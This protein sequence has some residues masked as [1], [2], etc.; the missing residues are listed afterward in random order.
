MNEN[1]NGGKSATSSNRKKRGADSYREGYSFEDKVA[2]LYRLLHYNVEHGRIFGGRQVDLFITTSFGDMKL[3]RAIECKAGAVLVEHIDSFIAKLRLVR[4]EYPAALGTI[5]SG[6][7]FTDAVT[8]HAVREGIQL[9]LHRDL[10]AQLFDGYGYAQNLL[11]ECESS[12]RYRIPLYIEPSIGYDTIGQGINAFEVID[13]W[14]ND[15]E[16]NQLTLL[17]DA[18]TGKSFLSRMIAYRLVQE[19][20]KAPLATLFFSPFTPS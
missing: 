19:Y 10:A 16:W 3:Q 6:V 7:S 20:L 18:G 11:R 5:V 14:L 15:P 13:Q 12:T 2:E 9:T 4:C 8:A 1:S 17:G